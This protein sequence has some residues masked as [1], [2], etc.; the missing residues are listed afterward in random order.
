MKKT[1]LIVVIVLFGWSVTDGQIRQSQ[2]IRD[3]GDRKVRAVQEDAEHDRRLE[4]ESKL[5][6]PKPA[7]MNVDV[8]MVLSKADVK[9]FAEA[10]AVEAKK[11]LD[12]EPV[13]MYLKFKSKLGDYVIT[14]RNPEDHEKLKYT[15]YAE[16]GPRGDI[17]ALYQYSIQFAAEDLPSTEFKI[18]LAPGV[19][20][21][22]KAIPILLLLTN[23][24]KSGVWNNEFRLT[25]TL[26]FPRSLSENL[27]MSPIV[28]DFSGGVTKY[29]KMVSEYDSLRLRG[30]TDVSRM[31]IAGTY[32]SKE[33][34]ARVE[35][36][37]ATEKIQPLKIYF[38]GDD[39]EEL[40]SFAPSQT[41]RR[42]IVATF[43]YRQGEECRYGVAEINQTFDFSKDA[44]VDPEIKLQKDLPADCAE[45]N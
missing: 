21:R 22:N 13:W 15:L 25:N 8:Q 23:T 18:G 34:K 24:T 36:K 42:R 11:I 38:A 45:A 39:W 29:Q 4:E 5:P 35:E 37:L 2:R 6:V 17:T 3:R 9:T 33:L 14:T 20:G 41:K 44:Y 10:K 26:T 27:A 1:V 28:I 32:F 31:P 19:L 16:V 7:V 12:G 43:T 40:A 30:T